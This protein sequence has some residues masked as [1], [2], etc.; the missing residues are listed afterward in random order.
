M[1]KVYRN[2]H[3]IAAI[4]TSESS[5]FEAAGHAL[6]R[7][8]EAL[9]A[10][11]RDNRPTRDDVVYSES[12]KLKRVARRYGGEPLS[13]VRDWLLYNDSPAAAHKEWGHYAK[14]RDGTRGKWVPGQRVFTKLQA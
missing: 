14:R 1:A 4:I 6:K 8:A 7:E 2:A 9:A 10:V 5:V 12:F 3:M 13:D 11:H